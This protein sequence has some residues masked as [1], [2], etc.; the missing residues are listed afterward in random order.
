MAKVNP[1]PS[2]EL[3]SGDNIVGASVGVV[4]IKLAQNLPDNN[5]HKSWLII[6]APV[7][8]LVIRY[9]WNLLSPE[10]AFMIKT[11]RVDKNRKKLIN[12]IN[13]LLKDDGISE[14]R[15]AELK[16]QR[17]QMKLSALETL[18]ERFKKILF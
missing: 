3:R 11:R 2:K 18:Q 16:V 4:L 15:K 1:R 6:I 7:L 12:K 5:A 8:A 17:E 13:D 14:G 10:I 9:V